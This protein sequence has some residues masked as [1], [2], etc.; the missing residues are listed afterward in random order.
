MFLPDHLME[1]FRLAT[2][3]DQNT[4]KSMISKTQILLESRNQPDSN[5]GLFHPLFVLS[6]LALIILVLTI[7]KVRYA[8]VLAWFDRIFFFLVGFCGI[9]I[10][11]LWFATDHGITANNL[12]LFWAIPTHML[13]IFWTGISKRSN[14]IRLYFLGTAILQGVLL[15][16][17][18]INPQKLNPALIPIILI[19]GIRSLQIAS[20]QSPLRLESGK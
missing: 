4:N 3:S 11:F 14:F 18:P 7:L 8:S 20:S 9:L 1:A 10:C 16:S 12:N 19:L 6:L 5:A 13:V 15:I 17:W 2:I